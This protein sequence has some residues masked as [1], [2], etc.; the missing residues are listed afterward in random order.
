M[1]EYYETHKSHVARKV[2]QFDLKGNFIDEWESAA[3]AVKFLNKE[4]C[5][6]T[7]V[8]CGK[9]NQAHNFIW[10]YKDE[11][12]DIPIKIKVENKKG[13]SLPIT[14]YSLDDE[15][16]QQWD[17]LT[18][19]AEE[20]GYSLGNFSTYCNGRKDHIYKGYKYYRGEKE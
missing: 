16:I 17:T 7:N 5:T 9:R 4:G 10:K 6:I 12:E 20:L 3:K 19:A 18:I 15:F 11:F 8:C 1:I 14:Q 2:L 13:A